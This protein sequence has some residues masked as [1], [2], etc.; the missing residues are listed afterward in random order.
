LSIKFTCRVC[1]KKNVV[2]LYPDYSEL[3]FWCANPKCGFPIDRDD[4]PKLDDQIISLADIWNQFWISQSE[5]RGMG[6]EEFERVF[7]NVGSHLAE[8]ISKKYE[9][10]FDPDKATV[11]Y[12][13]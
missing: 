5:N 12:G 3:P 2:E 10:K 4:L 1:G 8:E 6:T 13:D 11:F 9:C 7:L